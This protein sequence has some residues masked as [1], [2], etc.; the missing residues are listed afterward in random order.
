MSDMDSQNNL[1]KFKID[2]P[3]IGHYS[4][5]KEWEAVCWRKI[6]KSKDFLES[7]VTLYERHNLVMRAAVID[8]MVS[9]KKYR[10]IAKELWLSQQTISAIIKSVKENSY[11]SYRERGKTERKKKVYSFRPKKKK[12][13]RGRR[14]RTKYGP[15][16]VK[17]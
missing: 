12:E 2:L 16:H 4:S 3:L 5:R 17:F 9:G 7:L 15:M 11:R 10:E 13:Y 6:L 1:N 14:I 8:G